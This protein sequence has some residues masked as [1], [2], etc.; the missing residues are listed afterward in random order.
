MKALVIAEIGQNHNGDMGIAKE[1]IH[2][3]KEK[4]ADIAKFQI[5]DVDKIFKPD[6]EWY[7]ESKG[8]QLDRDQVFLLKEECDKA[9]IMRGHRARGRAQSAA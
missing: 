6:F 4:G 2:I 3:A 8:A 9:G 7:K 5:Y 1:L